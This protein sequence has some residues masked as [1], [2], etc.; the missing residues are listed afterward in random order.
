MAEGKTAGE[1]RGRS[2]EVVYLTAGNA[3]RICKMILCMSVSR[4]VPSFGIPHANYHKAM[5]ASE[6]VKHPLL[7]S[8]PSL[9]RKTFQPA[10]TKK[11]RENT[12]QNSRSAKLDWEEAV[13]SALTVASGGDV[14]GG[15]VVFFVDSIALDAAEDR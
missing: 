11:P 3:I 15:D 2:W 7:S 1:Y 10:S 4:C 14:V 12:T 9:Q 8:N 13:D 5:P 6:V